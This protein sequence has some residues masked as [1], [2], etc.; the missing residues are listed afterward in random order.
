[1][2]TQRPPGRLWKRL[3][4]WC[5]GPLL[6]IAI[7]GI[8][9]L[10]DPPKT[11]ILRQIQK[12]FAAATGLELTF[13]DK[14]RVVLW[15]EP[16]V[17][18]VD[19]RL[20]RPVANGEIRTVEIGETDI[21]RI[22][23]DRTALL[24]GNIVATEV[25]MQGPTLALS[26]ADLRRVANVQRK[27]SGSRQISANKLTITDGIFSFARDID[28]NPVARIGIKTL[29]LSGLSTNGIEEFNGKLRWRDEDVDL[30]GHLTRKPDGAPSDLNF[31]LTSAKLKLKF[32]GAAKA[33]KRLF[34]G[35]VTVETGS[36]ADA[37][38]WLN[39]APRLHK[40]EGPAEVSGQ[41]AFEDYAIRWRDASFKT[42]S[43]A[44][45][46]SV[47]LTTVDDRFRIIGKIDWDNLNV[48]QAFGLQ[49]PTMALAVVRTQPIAGLVLPSSF[50]AFS[51]YL[52]GLARP[53]GAVL[54]ATT[55]APA[56]PP[57][58]SPLWSRVLFDPT[59]LK[60]FDAD[61]DQTAKLLIVKGY[62]LRD[63][64]LKSR[65]MSGALELSIARLKLAD[66]SVAGRVTI[67]S[68]LPKPAISADLKGRGLA[69]R[70]VLAPLAYTSIV[71]GTGDVDLVLTGTGT[72]LEGLA[73]TMRG[74]VD[75]KLVKG[76]IIGF[77]LRNVLRQWWR[78]WKF[79]TTS[80]TAYESFVAKLR[81]SDGMIK[82]LGPMQLRGRDVEIDASGNVSLLSQ[83]LDQRVRIRLAPPPIG[84][85]IPVRV[86][87]AWTAPKVALDFGQLTSQ[88]DDFDVPP[89]FG[90]SA[91][92][93]PDDLR[94]K[95]KQT[96]AD[97]QRAS[98]IPEKLRAIF[99]RL[100]RQ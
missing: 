60:G 33:A 94:A 80:S 59:S 15:P 28:V 91:A 72:S 7:V 95:I 98:R 25:I 96:L 51:S 31:D 4:F 34:A 66:G 53:P 41:F 49:A 62:N 64:A 63:V 47:D 93:L 97:K 37:L 86:S 52:D 75:L 48:D 100:L 55:R 69:V 90:P 20:L 83:I 74:T 76:K 58:H 89:A 32:D 88:P 68:R 67:D 40:L 12:E 23:L 46:M 65:L 5:V 1:M 44:G 84:L 42:R 57:K 78:S 30:T 19:L 81:V 71:R 87:G 61:L 13:S 16:L 10:Q 35:R 92:R 38:A 3:L 27:H 82:T 18:F 79:S 36:I 45:K 99:E 2:T 29:F 14:S 11:S 70:S 50:D 39:I 21:L 56:P 43:T 17:E 8:G 85:P 22:R 9:V 6:S 54:S 73:P 26:A 77:D 24:S